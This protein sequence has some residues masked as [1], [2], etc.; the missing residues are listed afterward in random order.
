MRRKIIFIIKN[1]S[2]ALYT[3][4]LICNIVHDILV[5]FLTF[6][7]LFCVL[8]VAVD[9]GPIVALVVP[10]V[11]ADTDGAGRGTAAVERLGSGHW[12]LCKDFVKV[13]GGVSGWGSGCLWKTAVDTTSSAN[14][15]SKDVWTY[16]VS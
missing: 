2:M 15:H 5:V 3:L 6:T 13:V 16:P 8:L 7:S 9:A 10:K 14:I 1:A 4:Q 12:S 11:A